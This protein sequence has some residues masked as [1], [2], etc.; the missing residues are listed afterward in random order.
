MNPFLPLDVCI[1]DG[2]P[3][4]FGDRVYLYGSY[5]ITG[6][7]DYCSHRYYVYSASIYDLSTWTN[8]GISFSS[9]GV[10]SQ[11]PWSEE[12]LFAPDVIEKKGTYYLYFCLADGT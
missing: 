7:L 4:V 6:N 11:V 12:A 9:K 5:D 1:P 2:E 10:D 8:H 3:R